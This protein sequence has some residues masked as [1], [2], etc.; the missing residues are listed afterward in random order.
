M[1]A[2]VFKQSA[3]KRFFAQ[4]QSFSKSAKNLEEEVKVRSNK[5]KLFLKL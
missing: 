4:I 2:K 5:S 3:K 1:Q